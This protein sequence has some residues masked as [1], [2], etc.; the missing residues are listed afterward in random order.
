[1]RLNNVAT[2][3]V[4]PCTGFSGTVLSN[5]LTQNKPV[6]FK[7]PENVITS[8]EMTTLPHTYITNVLCHK[9]MMH[10]VF[11]MDMMKTAYTSLVGWRWAYE[12]IKMACTYFSIS[13]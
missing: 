4:Y 8:K 1:M 6:D 7:G 12:E 10:A 11:T 5:K 13:M 3:P 2:L 9:A